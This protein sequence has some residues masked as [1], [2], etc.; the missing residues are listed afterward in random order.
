[1]VDLLCVNAP[2]EVSP[3][4]APLG[5]AAGLLMHMAWHGMDKWPQ[6]DYCTS[7]HLA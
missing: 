5:V 7:N 1:M 6:A 4:M 2:K 3:L